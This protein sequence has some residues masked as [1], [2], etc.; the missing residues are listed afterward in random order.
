VGVRRAPCR[1]R[2]IYFV[3]ESFLCL[4]LIFRSFANVPDAARKTF[5]STQVEKVLKLHFDKDNSG[6]LHQV[7]DKA[8]LALRG[9]SVFFHLM[10]YSIGT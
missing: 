6:A 10:Q 1:V 9:S 3:F 7:E 4:F 8:L 5:L 2:S